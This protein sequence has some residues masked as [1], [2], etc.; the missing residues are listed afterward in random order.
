LMWTLKYTK[1][2]DK[3]IKILSNEIIY[4]YLG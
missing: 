3:S 4:V 2:R 1:I